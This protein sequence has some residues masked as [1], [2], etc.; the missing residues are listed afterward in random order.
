MF[1]ILGAVVVGIVIG[2]AVD[3]LLKSKNP[4]FLKGID[5]KVRQGVRAIKDAFSEGYTEATVVAEKV[6]STT[7]DAPAI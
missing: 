1:K 3:E 5:A 4:D 6:E 2:A 7:V